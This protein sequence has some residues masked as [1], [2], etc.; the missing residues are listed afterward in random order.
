MRKIWYGRFKWLKR[1][2][3]ICFLTGILGIL[4]ILGISQYIKSMANGYMTADVPEV[5]CIL[6]LGAGLTEEG[7]PSLVLRDRLD[8]AIELYQQGISDR[9]LMS[10]D[11]GRESYNEVNAMKQYAVDAGIPADHIFMDHA[12]FSTY[13]SIYRAR[14]VF[15]VKSLAIVTQP[16]HEYRAV[17]IAMKLGLDVYGTPS[18]ATQYQGSWMLE[19]RE[20]LARTKEFFNL[21]IQPEP[22]YLGEPISIHGSGSQTD[23]AEQVWAVSGSAVNGNVTDNETNSSHRAKE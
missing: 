7:T 17:Y 6:I 21:V 16:Y 3:C 1:V 14:D 23:D 15:Q 9:L 11:H 18:K 10:G 19:M 2:V 12:G 8:K 22:T 5:D 13:E 20:K 4:A